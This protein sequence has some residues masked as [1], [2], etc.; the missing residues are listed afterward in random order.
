M[1]IFGFLEPLR[2]TEDLSD[3]AHFG[4]T[5][6]GNPEAAERASRDTVDAA[7]FGPEISAM[8]GVSV[9]VSG[10]P[11][12]L[13]NDP[14]S[15]RCT[16][17]AAAVLAAYVKFGPGFLSMLRGRYSLAVVDSGARR[18]ILAVDAMAIEP[19][20]YAQLGRG[21]VFSS[22]TEAVARSP[23]IR[24]GVNRQAIF[25]YLVHHVVPAPDT[26]FEHVKKLRAGTHLILE[27]G[28]VRIARHWSPCFREHGQESFESLRAGLQASLRHA[29]T[30]CQP[31][32]H[33]GAFLSGGLDSSTVAGVLSEIG[34]RPTKTFTIG[35]GYEEYDELPYA[36]IANR[37]FGCDGHEYIIRGSDIAETFSQIA[38]AYDEPFGNSSALP[39]YYCA[40]LARETG[41]DHLLAGDGGDELFAG[42]SRYAEQIVFERYQLAPRFLRRQFLEPLLNG[43]PDPFSIPLI[44]KA[45][46]Y[47]EKANVPLPARLESWNFVRRLGAAAI[48]DPGLMTAVDIEQPWTRMQEVWNAA[49]SNSALQRML[50]CDWQYTLA[51]NDLRKVETMSALAGVRVSYPMLHPDV[52]ALSTRIPPGL[53]MPGTKLRD[54]YKRAMTGFLPEEIIRKKKHGFG[55]PFGLWLQES[56]PLRD[57][58]FGNLSSLR[59]RQ[60]I[61]PGFLDRLVDLHGQ[62]DAR[63]YGVFIWVLAMLEQWFQE[64]RIAP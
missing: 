36:R 15:T 40:R 25:D 5:V 29:V 9:A 21:I 50:F 4:A 49:P 11:A 32:E 19:L 2:A 26:I 47:V 33:S 22:S 3:L 39:V 23:A 20:A 52:V 44:R 54:F 45:R 48:L 58:V 16:A 34:T 31:G 57:L 41:V 14:G 35:F 61:R 12:W 1:P 24:A 43:W 28:R 13:I 51:D 60:L 62:E 7:C 17:S 18:V 6:A 63:Y 8:S 64:H 37:R 59:S 55:L 10:G 30:D 38:R 42:N 46:G 53:M 27:D 56:K